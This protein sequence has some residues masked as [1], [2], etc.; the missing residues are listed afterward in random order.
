MTPKDLIELG[1]VIKKF[2]KHMDIRPIKK[3][4]RLLNRPQNQWNA[5]DYSVAKHIINY[6]INMKKVKNEV[7]IDGLP[8]KRDVCLMIW[9][10]NP[11]GK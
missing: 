7:S 8:T 1:N 2:H 5:N 9:G 4:L 10:H 11:G 3:N 6:I